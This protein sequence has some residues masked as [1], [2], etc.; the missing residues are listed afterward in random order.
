MSRKK[1][2]QKQNGVIYYFFIGVVGIVVWSLLAHCNTYVVRT[3]STGTLWRGQ[4]PPF[5]YPLSIHGRLMY[6][7]PVLFLKQNSLT[8]WPIIDDLDM[9]YVTISNELALNL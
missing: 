7:C 3:R 8:I 5:S 2:K 6:I 1:G 4:D 9:L